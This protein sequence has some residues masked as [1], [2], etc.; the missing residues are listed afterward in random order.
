[1]RQENSELVTLKEACAILGV[2]RMTLY[3]IMGEGS[4]RSVP[5]NPNKL[6]QQ[7]FFMRRE[8]ERL[9]REGRKPMQRRAS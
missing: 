3:R 9:V 1:M 6:R 2:S 5:G 8:L 7:R 4:V